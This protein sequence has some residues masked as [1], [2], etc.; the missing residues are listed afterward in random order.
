M[1]V[2]SSTAIP[3]IPRRLFRIFNYPPIVSEEQAS[4]WGG[5]RAHRLRPAHGPVSRTQPAASKFATLDLIDVPF[6]PGS[7]VVNLGDMLERLT[8]GRYTSALHR[9]RNRSSRGV[10][11]CRSSSIPPSMPSYIRYRC[12]AGQRAARAAGTLGWHRAAR[13]ARHL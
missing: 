9:A 10:C 7:F 6:V 5:R 1:S 12:R 4:A 3:R 13:P 8:A 11:R 2:I